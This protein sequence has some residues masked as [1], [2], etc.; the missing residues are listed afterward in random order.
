MTDEGAVALREMDVE[1]LQIKD[2]FTSA[3]TV[4][5]LGQLTEHLRAAAR[6]VEGDLRE[7]LQVAKTSGTAM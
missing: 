6:G 3:L 5:Q 2:S 4:K 7:I 1:V